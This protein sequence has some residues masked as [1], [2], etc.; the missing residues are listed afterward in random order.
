[1][2]RLALFVSLLF[3]VSLSPVA[4]AADDDPEWVS[5]PGSK[6]QQLDTGAWLAVCRHTTVEG[7]RVQPS[8]HT[9]ALVGNAT[10]ILALDADPRLRRLQVSA[11][12]LQK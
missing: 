4:A 6:I 7:A 1:M 5:L 9:R 8:P 10:R 12:V 11:M 3:C 2:L